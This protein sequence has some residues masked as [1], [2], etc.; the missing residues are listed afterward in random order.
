MLS[1]LAASI[2]SRSMSYYT[3]FKHGWSLFVVLT[4]VSYWFLRHLR[5]PFVV[6][7]Y[8]LVARL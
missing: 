4:G 3:S 1:L 6:E 8:Y 7:L 5:I 2:E